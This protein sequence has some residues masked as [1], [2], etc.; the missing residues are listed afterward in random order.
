MSE[1]RRDGKGPTIAS[2]FAQGLFLPGR[3]CCNLRSLHLSLTSLGFQRPGKEWELKL[4]S[5]SSI[6]SER[7]SARACVGAVCLAYQCP[8]A[9][10]RK[11]RS[12]EVPHLDSELP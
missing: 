3:L 12:G 7:R 11:V 9:C 2:T 1:L 8:S 5:V 10:T 6:T 4:F